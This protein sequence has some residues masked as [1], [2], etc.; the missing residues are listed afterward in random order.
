MVL[1]PKLNA[2]PVNALTDALWYVN[3]PV[4]VMRVLIFD[5]FVATLPLIMARLLC[6]API[7]VARLEVTL[8]VAIWV[9]STEI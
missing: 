3:H 8:V 2:T 9:V 1:W 6:N 5:V 7:S 4:L